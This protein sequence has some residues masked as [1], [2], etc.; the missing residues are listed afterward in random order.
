[1][2]ETKTFTDAKSIEHDA[3][4]EMKE[5]ADAGKCKFGEETKMTQSYFD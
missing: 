2:S 4:V 3:S 5:D 1:M